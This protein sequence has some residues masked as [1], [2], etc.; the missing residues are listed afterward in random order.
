MLKNHYEEQDLDQLFPGSV[1]YAVDV[2]LAKFLSAPAR[3]G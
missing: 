2:L 3:G 1:D